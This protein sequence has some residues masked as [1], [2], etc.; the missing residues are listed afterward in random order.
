MSK[1]SERRAL[2]KIASGL[3]EV[4]PCDKSYEMQLL[5]AAAL[6]APSIEPVARVTA[7]D[8]MLHAILGRCDGEY[9]CRICGRV[10]R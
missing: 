5:A 7:K 3:P 1:S 2:E 9:Y 8:F 6:K 4:Q 10:L